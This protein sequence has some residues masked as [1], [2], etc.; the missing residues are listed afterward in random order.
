MAFDIKKEYIDH[1]VILVIVMLTGPVVPPC[2]GS[3][4]I[5]EHTPGFCLLTI[6]SS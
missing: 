4:L 3:V 1:F 2:D 5:A 6:T